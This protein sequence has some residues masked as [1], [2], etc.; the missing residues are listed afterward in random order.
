M[1]LTVV[2]PLVAKPIFPVVAAAGTVA[3]ICVSEFT[4]IVAFLPLNTTSVV[5]VS[6]VPVIVTGVPGAPLVGLKLAIVGV[7]RKG[8]ELVSEVDPVV[9]VT[10]PVSA[11]AGTFTPRN[12]APANVMAVAGVPAKL[13]VVAAVKP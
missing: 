5:C 13:T 3:V 1:V 2:P 6:P 7:T 8:K 12:F 4:V 11:P 9:T 10:D